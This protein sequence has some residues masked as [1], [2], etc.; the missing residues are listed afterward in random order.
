MKI[1]I[2]VVAYNRL[3]SLQRLLRSVEDAYYDEDTVNLIISIDKSDSDKVEGWAGKYQWHHG[4][5]EVIIHQN[6]LGLRNHVLECGKR[7]VDYDA[8]IVLEDDITVTPIFYRYAK[9]CVEFYSHDDRIAGIS[10]Y[11][12][13][14][15][16]QSSLPFEPVKSEYDVFFMN[17][18]QS[19][20]QVW[21]KR[22]WLDFYD[23]YCKDPSEIDYA[24]YLTSIWHWPESS[25]LKYHMKYCLEQNKYFVYPYF[26]LS[27]NNSEIGTHTASSETYN[28]AK[29]QVLPQ[30]QFKLVTLDDAPI[31]Y[32]AFFE[33]K[34]LA[35]YVGVADEDLC[36]DFHNEKHNR[37]GKRYWLTTSAQP[38]K[39]VRS[40]SLQLKPY[41]HNI[42]QDRRGHQLFLYDTSI[43]AKAP[44][45]DK[46]ALFHYLYGD[47]LEMAV[48]IL[49]RKGVLEYLVIRSLKNKMSRLGKFLKEF[50]HETS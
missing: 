17:V 3:E 10:L 47:G 45:V 20:G 4:Q 36:V 16:F 48:Q 5:Y 32:D 35:K 11:G 25:W 26:S 2:V 21:M 39:V 28:Q 23:W 50:G 30:K 1:A 44:V 46:L 40:F 42:L 6:K 38:Y 29:L 41:E 13:V 43:S 12:F 9:Q 7:V 22:Q 27:T 31:K 37:L 34:F 33:A 14:R 24:P 19:W 49:G 8:I 18:A 15:N